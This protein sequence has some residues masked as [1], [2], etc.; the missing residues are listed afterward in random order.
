MSDTEAL[1]LMI[2]LAITSP[3][4]AK[5]LEWVAAAE[6]LAATMPEDDVEQAKYSAVA[7]VEDEVGTKLTLARTSLEMSADPDMPDFDELFD[8]LDSIDALIE[9]EEDQ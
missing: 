8:V 7:M 3:T 1:S 2:A 9:N 6:Q 4:G 5:G